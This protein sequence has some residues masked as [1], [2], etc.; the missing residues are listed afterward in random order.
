ML[1]T[2]QLIDKY[3]LKNKLPHIWCAGCGDGAITAAM[4]R[5]IDELGLDQD[6]VSMVNG[7]GCS[8]RT[9]AYLDFDVIK[10]THGRALGFATGLKL[11]R[12][13]LTVIS[14]AGDGDTGAIGGNHF[15]HAARRN[16]DITCVV[17][18][19]RI[20]G[21]TGGQSSPT[22]PFGDR[23]ST[24]PYGTTEHPFDLCKLATAAGATY[25]AR[26][27]AY[28]IRQLQRIFQ[29]AIAHKG[30]SMVEVIS[31]CP[32][33][34]GRYNEASSPAEMLRWQ[35]DSSV[36]VTAAA[37]MTPEQLA[38]KIVIG[39][40]VSREDPEYVEEYMKLV[41]QQQQREVKS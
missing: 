32:I 12:P 38:G 13:E 30:F 19:N 31:Q 25:V 21:M 8:G 20:Y 36:S 7:I 26:S 17:I 14:V 15:I 11:F 40:F 5:A 16:I 33:Y 35:K 6:K 1:S 18:N 27:T 34:Y 23:A 9:G 29:K 28:H 3:Y 10:G 41:A 22:T 39:E 4:V 37:S 2:A 24:A